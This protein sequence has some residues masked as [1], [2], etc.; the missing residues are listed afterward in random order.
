MG[1]GWG[2]SAASNRDRNVTRRGSPLP[3]APKEAV[4]LAADAKLSGWP[5]RDP[6]ARSNSRAAPEA[7]QGRRLRG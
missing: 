4:R 3:P 5:C 6:A 2:E 1:V 7:G